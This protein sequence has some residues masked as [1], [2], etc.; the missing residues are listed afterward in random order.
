MEWEEEQEADGERAAC[1]EEARAWGES[2]IGELGGCG[3]MSED[4]EMEDTSEKIEIIVDSGCRR[5][6]VKSK[7]FKGI[8]VKGS[9]DVGKNF[10]P[11]NAAHVPNQGETIIR[12]KHSGGQNLRVVAQVA[13][14]TKNSA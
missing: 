12:G 14:V 2:A 9:E 11:A 1:A 4:V 10:R 5:T 3:V 6:I 8:K 7:A 13:D